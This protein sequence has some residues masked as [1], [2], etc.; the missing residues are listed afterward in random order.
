MENDEKVTNF[1][2]IWINKFKLYLYYLGS[3]LTFGGLYLLFK[4]ISNLHFFYYY[5]VDN[6]DDA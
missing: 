3:I 4:W 6:I 5:I 1:Y 2:F